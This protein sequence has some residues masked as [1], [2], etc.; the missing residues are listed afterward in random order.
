[1]NLYDGHHHGEGLEHLFCEEGLRECVLFG[2]MKRWLQRDLA[3][4]WSY[5]GKTVQN[6][7]E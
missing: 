1:M 3:E 7:I 2:L 4:A 6:G 5:L